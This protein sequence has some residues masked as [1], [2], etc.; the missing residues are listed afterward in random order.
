MT[1]RNAVMF[2]RICER[3]VAAVHTIKADCANGLR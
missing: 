1:A 3:M 2:G